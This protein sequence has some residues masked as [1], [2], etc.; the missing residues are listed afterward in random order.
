MWSEEGGGREVGT[1]LL[2]KMSHDVSFLT[3]VR[4]QNITGCR[5]PRTKAPSCARR[6]LQYIVGGWLYTVILLW[7]F[8][9]P[10]NEI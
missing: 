10:H 1:L 7:E 5:Q 8:V 3:V 9:R 6:E 4:R 2:H